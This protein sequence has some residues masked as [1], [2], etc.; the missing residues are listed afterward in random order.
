MKTMTQKFV[1]LFSALF[2]LAIAPVNANGPVQ[3]APAASQYCGVYA[4]EIGLYVNRNWD[5]NVAKI[6]TITSSCDVIVD[7]YSGLRLRIF[8]LDGIIIGSEEVPMD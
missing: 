8:I 1:I 3:S 4:D 6:T 2:L 5:E 7:C